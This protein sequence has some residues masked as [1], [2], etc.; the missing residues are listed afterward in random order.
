MAESTPYLMYKGRPLVRSGNM[1]YYGNMA[2]D[3][4]VMMQILTTKDANDMKMAEKIQIQ[5]L[6]TDPETP[7]PDRIL[8]TVEKVGLYNAMEIADIWLNRMK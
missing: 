2:D 7:L 5:L 4:V 3:H 8:K 1:L 6:S